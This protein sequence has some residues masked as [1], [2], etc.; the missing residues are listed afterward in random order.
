MDSS[1]RAALV[2][3]PLDVARE[4]PLAQKACLHMSD[5]RTLAPC[6]TNT[7]MSYRLMAGGL[8]VAIRPI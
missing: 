3:T 5:C 1:A 4:M 8:D 6:V 2:E 7:H